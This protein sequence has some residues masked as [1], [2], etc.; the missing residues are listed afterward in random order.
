MKP[1][2]AQVGVPLEGIWALG[3]HGLL[4]FEC[5]TLPGLSR[6][7]GL[8]LSCSDPFLGACFQIVEEWEDLHGG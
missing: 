8:S 7:A 5:E 6:N 3:R 1:H 2:L 4:W